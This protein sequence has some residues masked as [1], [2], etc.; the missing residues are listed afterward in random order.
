MKD[1]EEEAVQWIQLA[2]RMTDEQKDHTIPLPVLQNYLEIAVGKMVGVF[3]F[4]LVIKL[5]YYII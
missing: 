3:I 2:V 4:C 5:I 1:L